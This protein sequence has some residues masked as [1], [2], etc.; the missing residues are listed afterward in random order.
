LNEASGDT[1]W[2][3]LGAGA[4][5]ATFIE[6]IRLAGTAGAAGFLAGRGIWG[7]ALAADPDETE[8]IAAAVC[9]PDLERCRAMAERVARPLRVVETI[10][11]AGNG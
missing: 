5:T 4:D 9:R 1:P 6:Q 8:R 7:A 3:L 2:V 10:A 11:P